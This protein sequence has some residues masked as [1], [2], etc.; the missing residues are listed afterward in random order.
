MSKI[1]SSK[2]KTLLIIIGIVVV[3]LTA[4]MFFYLTGIGAVDSKS[5][6]DVSVTIPQGSGAAAIVKIL[7]EKGLVR[8]TLCAKIHARIGGFFAGQYLCF[9]QIHV[10][11]GNDESHQRGRF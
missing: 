3:L 10:P 6:K 9:Q 11:A 2:L 1:F 5:D 8:N 4:V 7:D